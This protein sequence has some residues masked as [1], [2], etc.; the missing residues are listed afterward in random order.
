ML[1]SYS[2]PTFQRNIYSFIFGVE[3]LSQA[4]EQR[5]ASSLRH[6]GFFAWLTLDPE[7]GSD[8][9]LKSRLTIIGHT[10]LYPER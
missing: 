3:V 7:D 8:V 10:T 2:Q 1:S 6:I 9:P 5:E 4:R